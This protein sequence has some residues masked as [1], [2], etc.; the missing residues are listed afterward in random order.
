[1]ETKPFPK[2]QRLKQVKSVISYKENITPE[3]ENTTPE[4][5]N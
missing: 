3:G 1:M 5:E 4:K 2:R